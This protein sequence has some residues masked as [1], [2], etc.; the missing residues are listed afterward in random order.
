MAC[1]V[2]CRNEFHDKIIILSR[3]EIAMKY[4]V[5]DIVELFQTKEKRRVNKI[6]EGVQADIYG[7]MISA[8][9]LEGE[10]RLFVDIYDGTVGSI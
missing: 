5:G 10:S 1:L 2:T 3:E 8:Y 7:N 9:I 4:K 6:V